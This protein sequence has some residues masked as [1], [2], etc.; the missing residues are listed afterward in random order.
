MGLLKLV[1][2]LW[3]KIKPKKKNPERHVSEEELRKAK[4][5]LAA[6]LKRQEKEQT[7]EHSDNQQQDN[8]GTEEKEGGRNDM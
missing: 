6:E 2:M 4:K 3:D 5:N 8:A 1:K 7:A